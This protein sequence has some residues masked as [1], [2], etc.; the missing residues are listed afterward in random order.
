MSRTVLL[1]TVGLVY[2]LFA[3]A[4]FRLA[5]V[6]GDEVTISVG[7][8][9]FTLLGAAG[10]LAAAA[11]GRDRA[12]L[13]LAGTLPLVGWFIATP[14]NSGPPFLIVSLFAP[15]VALL[16]LSVARVRI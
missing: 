1:A 14:W 5:V 3:V 4:C 16:C 6:N 12:L 9:L 11:R 2:A 8:G 7:E 10:L 13:V 15:V